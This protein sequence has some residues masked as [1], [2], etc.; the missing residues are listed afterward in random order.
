VVSLSPL[1]GDAENDNNGPD[2][3]T[4]ATV[5]TE[6]ERDKI[7]ESLRDQYESSKEIPKMVETM[8]TVET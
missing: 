3:S 2:V 6:N 4:V 8:A 1:D 7:L 5:S